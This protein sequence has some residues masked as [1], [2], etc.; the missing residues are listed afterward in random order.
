MPIR[1]ADLARQ[2]R[3]ITVRFDGIDDALTVRINPHRMTPQK[4]IAFLAA[5]RADEATRA[6]VELLA[7]V[8]VG[9]DLL[10]DDGR[11]FPTDAATLGGLPSSLLMAT[12]RALGEQ[13][14]ADPTRPA[15]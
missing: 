12:M 6:T 10:D 9:W 2:V 4:E 8:L 14:A 7:D 1:L 11:P 15:S 3:T 13:Q 5:A